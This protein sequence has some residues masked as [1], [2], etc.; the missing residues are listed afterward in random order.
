MITI[1]YVKYYNTCTCAHYDKMMTVIDM[2]VYIHCDNEMNLHDL[3][4]K[5][6]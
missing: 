6:Y 4:L 1:L 3:Y 2:C 5:I